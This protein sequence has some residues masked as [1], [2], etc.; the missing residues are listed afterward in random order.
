MDL[1]SEILSREPD[2]TDDEALPMAE[3]NHHHKHHESLKEIFNKHGANPNSEFMR[4]LKSWKH[5]H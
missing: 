3:I 2:S 4:D 5:A 1:H